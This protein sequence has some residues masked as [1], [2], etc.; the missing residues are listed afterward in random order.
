MYLTKNR[1]KELEAIAREIRKLIIKT[2]HEA[3]CGHTGGSLSE[4]D[5]LSALFF[6]V[7]KIDPSNPKMENRD[8]FILSKGHATPGYYSALA[9]RGFF[10]SETL[11]TFDRIDSILQGHPDMN[12]TPGV[13]MSSGSL[14][15][16]LSVGIGMALAGLRK[17]LDFTTFV[18]MGDGE[19]AEGQL[20]EAIL[21]AGASNKRVKKIV[22]IT[23]YN[24]V[25]L[26]SKTSEAIDLDDL[27]DKYR[28]FGW[29]AYECNGHDMDDLDRTLRQARE[30][31][32]DGPVSVIAHTVKGK[33]VSFMEGEYQWHGKA[34]DEVQYA[35]A[36]KE[37]G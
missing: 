14:G 16:G 2:T 12:K 25:Q 6:D 35:Q 18:L 26:A 29:K 27:A 28:C 7:M 19:S 11:E 24:K 34:P 22:A 32:K 5:I 13:D 10:S 9:L 4:A 23:D 31:S 30:E 37:L 20:W 8:R 21:F 36:I 17:N 33:G 3:A 15:Q 1:V